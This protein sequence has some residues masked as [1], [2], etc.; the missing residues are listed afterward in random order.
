MW[1]S[2]RVGTWYYPTTTLLSL[3]A[4]V[5]EQS[6][7]NMVLPYYC[8]KLMPTNFPVALMLD[9]VVLGVAVLSR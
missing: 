8:I 7:W 6:R 5:G 3:C 2:N 1:V 9:A 4:Y